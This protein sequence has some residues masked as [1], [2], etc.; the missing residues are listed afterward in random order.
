MNARSFIS[1]FP[2]S[3]ATGTKLPV[4]STST[5][6]N[7]LATS[8]ILFIYLVLVPVLRRP[9]YQKNS[10]K[11][12]KNVQ[13]VQ[14]V[15]VQRTE[16]QVRSTRYG[17]QHNVQPST[18]FWLHTIE[19]AVLHSLKDEKVISTPAAIFVYL[20]TLFDFECFHF[21]S[22]ANTGTRWISLGSVT[23]K[24]DRRPKTC[25]VGNHTV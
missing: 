5:G 9:S 16:Y 13:N 2:C 19:E 18:T 7:L 25:H 23:I 14:N 1:F 20:Y 21:L 11:T 3:L 8:K 6:W 15:Q 4:T 10:N 12:L 17:V 24:A 22:T